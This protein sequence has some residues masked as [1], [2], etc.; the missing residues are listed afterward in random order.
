MNLSVIFIIIIII[1]W[2]YNYYGYHYRQTNLLK[3]EIHELVCNRVVCFCLK[4]EKSI[5]ALKQH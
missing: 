1:L 5:F 3:G 2:F 4:W